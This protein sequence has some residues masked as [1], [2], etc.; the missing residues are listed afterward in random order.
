MKKPKRTLGKIKVPRNHITKYRLVFVLVLIIACSVLFILLGKNDS[1]SK[2]KQSSSTGNEIELIKTTTD[3][4]QR[5]V[6]YRELIERV[7][8]VEAQELLLR[9][10]LPFTG[11]THLINHTL[12]TYLYEK[13]GIE[14]ISY[15]RDYFL[16]S[17]YHGLLLN[18]ISGDAEKDKQVVEKIVKHCKDAGPGVLPQCMHGVGHGYVP[19]VGYSNLFLA[20]EQ[21]DKLAATVQGFEQYNCLDGAFMENIWGV[22]SGEPSPDRLVKES[23]LLYPCNDS[24]MKPHYVNPCWSNQPSLIY[25]YSQGSI[26]K[27]S[28]VCM[29]LDQEAAKKTCFD[30][31][32]RQIHPI[33]ENKAEKVFALCNEI[34]SEWQSYCYL[35]NVNA[36]FSVGDRKMP[37]DICPQ[38]E[39]PA[40]AECHGNL[41][42]NINY[43]ASSKL[44]NDEWCNLI[45]DDEA[46]KSHCLQGFRR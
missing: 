30:G 37:F 31:L 8:P 32:A 1:D 5:A 29:G 18:V 40:K 45:K 19:A 9:S 6:Y 34:N 42:S 4:D 35:T 13:H 41:V 21:C 38:L 11:E 3:P 14:G 33:T 15:C 28:D 22:H 36:A 12:G 2:V 27:V 16:G 23:D 7:G 10:G 39:A 46:S 43:Y 44:Q 17:C 24:R 26:P 25:Q 20:L